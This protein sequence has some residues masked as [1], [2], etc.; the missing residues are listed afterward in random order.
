MLLILKDCTLI[1][2]LQV[3]AILTLLPRVLVAHLREAYQPEAVNL[4]SRICSILHPSEDDVGDIGKLHAGF[5]GAF[6]NG[7]RRRQCSEDVGLLGP[8]PV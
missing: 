1:S 2:S 4:C 5:S 6:T 3:N 7:N 8:A